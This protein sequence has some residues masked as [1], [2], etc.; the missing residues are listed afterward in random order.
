MQG[1]EWYHQMFYG[2]FHSY[3]NGDTVINGIHCRQ[4]ERK[5]IVSAYWSVTT[6]ISVRD[7]PT[8]YVYNNA[9][10]V[11]V[12]NQLFDWFTSLYLFNVHPGDSTGVYAEMIGGVYNGQVPYCH[13]TSCSDCG[14]KCEN[15][16][17]LD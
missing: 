6:G 16:Y 13:I 7:L 15:Y 14:T 17:G 10:T 4:V 8:L 3:Y 11:F 12:Y 5:A 9:D 1:G 2:A